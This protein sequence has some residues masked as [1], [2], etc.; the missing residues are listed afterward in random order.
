MKA[1]FRRSAGL[2][3][4]LAALPAFAGEAA[5]TQKPI[6]VQMYTLR[7]A[8]SRAVCGNASQ[9]SL[10]LPAKRAPAAITRNCTAT[11]PPS[12]ARETIDDAQR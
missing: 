2:I 10:C 9:R 3:L 12:R 1:L 5:S 7:D 4:L 8:G 6:A 11:A